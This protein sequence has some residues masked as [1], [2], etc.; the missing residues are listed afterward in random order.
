MHDCNPISKDRQIEH[1]TPG[2][3]GNGTGWKAYVEL[4]CLR[5]DLNMMVVDTDE[6]VGIIQTGKQKIWTDRSTF[7]TYEIACKVASTVF[8][9]EYFDKNRKELLNLVSA[10]EFEKIYENGRIS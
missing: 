8:T 5:E 7:F 1:Y 10:E 9:Y 2:E 3:A 6:G 4:R